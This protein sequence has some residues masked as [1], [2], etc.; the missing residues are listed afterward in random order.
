[1]RQ[2]GLRVFQAAAAEAGLE[3]RQIDCCTCRQVALPS[4]REVRQLDS[5]T[6]GRKVSLL[7][8]SLSEATTASGGRRRAGDV[9]MEASG[10]GS[11]EI[12]AEDE[13]EVE[14]DIRAASGVRA[15]LRRSLAG[16][17]AGLQLRLLLGCNGCWV[18]TERLL[19]FLVT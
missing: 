14:E 11:V 1:M 4:G 6:C 17:A 3:V 10:N 7:D 2:E 8:V 12:D 15:G 9:K 13:E 19:L 18:A 16:G 5:C